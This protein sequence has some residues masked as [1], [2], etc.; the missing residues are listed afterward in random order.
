MLRTAWSSLW[1]RKFR[2]LMSA[3]SIVLGVAFVA[4]SLMFTR[5][6]SSGF[7]EIVKGAL[8]DVNVTVEGQNIVSTRPPDRAYLLEPSVIDDVAARDDVATAVGL[9]TSNQVFVL[10]A[11]EQLVAFPE[12]PGMASNWHDVPAAG[13]LEG[14]R[15]VDG[16]A[17][18]SDDEVLIDPSTARRAGYTVGD[19]VAI[20]TPFDGVQRYRLAG[21]AAYGAGGTAGAGYVFFTTRE[22]QRLLTDGADAFHGIWV[23]AAPGVE[24]DALAEAISASLPEPFVARTGDVVA[25]ELGDL[26]DVGLGFVNAFLLVFAGIAV[27]VAMLL[28]LNTFSILV[29]QRARELALL[30]ALGAK[31]SQVRSVVLFEAALVGATGGVVGLAAGYGLVWAILALMRPIGIDPGPVA[32]QITWQI[33]AISL[34]LGVVMTVLA[35]L[36]PARK[37]SATRPIEAMTAVAA[38]STQRLDAA[39]TTGLVLIE[40]GAALL[41]CGVFLDVD[42]PLWWVG[43]GG[44]ALLVGLVLAATLVGAPV[45]GLFGWLLPRLFGEPGRLAGVNARRQPRRT[46]ATA[47][48]LMLGLSLVS[49]VAVLAASTTTSIREQLTADHRGDFLISPVGYQPFDSSVLDKAKA[50]DGVAAVHGFFVGTATLD[51]DPVTLGGL[52]PGALTEGTVVEGLSGTLGPEPDSA[53]I[54]TGVAREHGLSLGMMFDL[55]SPRGEQRVLVT[56]IYADEDAS[57]GDVV[58]NRETFGQLADDALVQRLVVD[59]APDASPQHVRAQL[60]DAVEGLPTVLVSDVEEYIAETLGQ[61]T[62]VFGLLYALLA[63]AIVISVLGIVNT[64]GLSVIERTREIGL[65]RAVGLTRPQVRRMVTLESVTVAVLGSLLGVLLGVVFGVA[66]ISLLRDSGIDRLVIPWMQLVIF[67]V[68]AAFFGWLAA[69]LPARRAG[70]LPVLDAIAVS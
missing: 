45:L 56:G 69:L 7:D 8:A 44:A 13:G 9:V 23:Q 39:G 33:V 47:A 55:A 59:I 16:Q 26:L 65:L 31:R 18:S 3:L 43:A 5:L 70:R 54:S 15:I 14:T 4:G 58:L 30:R 36:H 53:L 38:G 27:V 52:T 41:V 66:V 17:L 20:S 24:P 28:I 40:L 62:Q 19:E 12:M 2:L 48:T 61:F 50:A 21:T 49:V 6:L 25:E 11:D 60:R 35:A 68:V 63:L 51:G 32:P 64:L 29:A 34:G 42:A 22:A 46:A 37:A 57:L 10:D 67:I 1:A